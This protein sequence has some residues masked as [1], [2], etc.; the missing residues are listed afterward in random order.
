MKKLVCSLVCFTAMILNVQ[1]G[2]V[3]EKDPIDTPVTAGTA[4][5]IEIGAGI[6][7]AGLS[8]ANA[9]TVVL[10]QSFAPEGIIENFTGFE[11]ALTQV[12]NQLGVSSGQYPVMITYL[13]LQPKGVTE[14]TIKTLFN[15]FNIPSLYMVNNGQAALYATG[16]S[17]GVVLNAVN[18]TSYAVPV[19]EGYALPHAATR[20]DMG[21]GGGPDGYMKTLLKNKGRTV[22]LQE[23][24]NILYTTGYVAA[25]YNAE[26]QKSE[27]S[28]A[29]SYKLN[30][31]QT[32]SIGKERFKA[33]EALFQTQMMNMN[34][35]GL[36]EY[37]Y[38]VVMKCDV[39]LRKELYAN[40]ILSGNTTLFPGMK[41]RLRNEIAQLAPPTMNVVVTAP[42]NR[43]YLPWTGAKV[44]VSVLPSQAWL[45]KT[46]FA[47]RGIT[48]ARN[49]FFF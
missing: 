10:S 36:G 30:N 16:R 13:V 17:T 3:T 23:A 45:T 47:T 38:N 37:L 29:T 4:A 28:V 9:P 15:K 19:Q 2:T 31:G 26:L 46:E 35:A 43:E 42:A 18:N 44:L 27:G 41:E 7:H 33:P 6:L 8:S 34:S 25:N 1:A 22:S 40:I 20:F 32:I 14:N 48:I 21:T 49:K 24:R 39:D 11:N 5:V 12:Y